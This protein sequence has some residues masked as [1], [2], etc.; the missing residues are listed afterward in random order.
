MK[1][2]PAHSF[3]SRTGP[4][5]SGL[6]AS[7][8]VPGFAMLGVQ[9]LVAALSHPTTWRA[10]R[11]LPPAQ[12]L[13]ALEVTA[14]ILYLAAVRF[15]MRTGA[16][17]G[18]AAK[19]ALVWCLA[20]GVA[21]RVAMFFS[22]PMFEN[23]YYRYLWD[24][25]VTAH[26]INP[27]RVSPESLSTG[28]AGATI[29]PPTL[30]QLARDAVGVLPG[31][32]HPRLRTIYPPAAQAAFALAH[33]LSPW[34]L[35]AWRL[36]LLFCEAAGLVLLLR[37]VRSADRRLVLA[38]IYWWSPLSIKEI[39]NSAHMDAL[40]F[41]LLL[42]C[43][44]LASRKR[45]TGAAFLLALAAGVKVWP[46]LLAP[47]VLRPVLARPK[48]LAAALAAFVVPV[49][50][51]AIFMWPAFR[52]ADSG[53][54]TYSRTWEMNDALYMVVFW[55]TRLAARLSGAPDAATV[56][57]S[58]RAVIGVG[59]LAWAVWCARAR[60]DSFEGLAGRAGAV[61][62]ALF[63]FSPTQFPWYGLWLLPFLAIAP[64]R[65]LLLLQVT[66]PLYYLRFPM[67][68]A[69]HAD[70]FDSGVVWIEFGPVLALMSWEALRRYSARR[71]D[72]G[73]APSGR[74]PGPHSTPNEADMDSVSPSPAT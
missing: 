49:L 25:G 44:L 9:L 48:R 65:P 55:T 72:P 64:S 56:H 4:L 60:L 71:R 13:V 19:S 17:G 59:L 30:K 26:G 37:G 33:I 39:V 23:D 15:A 63:L 50:A 22:T 16:T 1:N 53:F 32:N 7:L 36:V 3:L 27:Y 5:P 8:A 62:A 43:L 66:L 42:G 67:Q 41:P 6:P 74:T 73:P 54:N 68:A 35:Q 45:T 46:V 24:G 2:G 28:R 69:G 51:M 70:L 10:L 31:V 47:L 38:V 34:D 18:A 58:A 61:T 40:L 20:I 52:G 14:G 11:A 57:V 21:M 29:V 12:T